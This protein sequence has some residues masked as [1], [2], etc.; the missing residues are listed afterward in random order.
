LAR[1]CRPLSSDGAQAQAWGY[2]E[3]ALRCHVARGVM[4]D[5]YAADPDSALHA[6]DEAAEIL[7]T[8]PVL[9]RARAKVLYR[10]KDHAGALAILR[11]RRTQTELNIP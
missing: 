7:G 11:V 6:L 2:R 5:E 4:F 9:S 8:D 10:R 3:L 1:L